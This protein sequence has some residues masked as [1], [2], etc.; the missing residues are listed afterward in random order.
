MTTY[1]TFIDEY[2]DNLV[3]AI[4]THFYAIYVLQK[5]IVNWKLFY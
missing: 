5:L 3:H 2:A 1:V 4:N